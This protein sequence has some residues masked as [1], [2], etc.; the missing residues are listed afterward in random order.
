MF[1]QG[2]YELIEQ[3]RDFAIEWHGAQS[4]GDY[5]YV[6]HLDDVARLVSPLGLDFVRAAYLHDVLEDTDCTWQRV[7]EVF[8]KDVCEAVKA[9]TDPPGATRAERKAGLAERMAGQ[10]IVPVAVKVADRL[11]NV[12]SSL[13]TI[14]KES[15][16]G[17]YA[18]EHE[19][20]RY[21]FWRLAML[22]PRSAEDGN[23]EAINETIRMLGVLDMLLRTDLA[24]TT[25]DDAARMSVVARSD[26]EFPD[27][28]VLVRKWDP[29][30]T[31]STI[32][33]ITRRP[34][35]KSWWDANLLSPT[36][37]IIREGDGTF[38]T[39]EDWHELHPGDIVRFGLTCPTSKLDFIHT[40][41]SPGHH[42]KAVPLPITVAAPL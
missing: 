5:P 39:P 41:R 37:M 33:P 25:D 2:D 26:R 22:S 18:A 3:A 36:D 24:D 29:D 9:L 14:G 20:F 30:P 27:R 34:M 8:G 11:A 12:A 13:R 15:R 19:T 40:L 7:E 16:L 21:M 35:P 38:S 31:K 10:G 6:K 42:F 23:P 1:K 17:M 28:I 32:F 4:Y